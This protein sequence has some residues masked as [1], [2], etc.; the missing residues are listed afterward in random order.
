MQRLE[1]EDVARFGIRV[2]QDLKAAVEEEAVHALGGEAT[3][4]GDAEAVRH[5]LPGH[6]TE[7]MVAYAYDTIA[8]GNPLGFF[9]MVHV[10]EGTSVSL[11]LMAA[12]AIQSALALPDATIVRDI[13]SEAHEPFTLGTAK[14]RGVESQGM[15]LMTTNAEGKLVFVNPDADAPNGSTVN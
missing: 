13:H 6:A 2:E 10:L 5:G 8:R 1:V 9:G 11:A 4:G 7:L 15:I 3:A 12:D 14:I